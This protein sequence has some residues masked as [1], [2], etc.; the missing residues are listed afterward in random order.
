MRLLVISL[1]NYKTNGISS[2][3]KNLYLSEA[4]ANTKIT[5]LLPDQS[6]PDRI[7]ELEG[8]GHTVILRPDRIKK[9]PQYMALIRKIVKQ[10]GIQIVHVHGNSRTSVIELLAAKQAK[11]SVRI[12]HGHNTGTKS[13][14]LHRMLT[15]LF[16]CVCTD[17][18]ACG[19]AAG[20][21][22]HGKHPFAVVNN[23]I[24]L[25]DFLFNSEARQTI[26]EKY[27]L[28]DRIVIGHV[29]YFTVVKNQA[30]LVD[31]L[32]KLHETDKR[33]CL[34]LIGDGDLQ[35]TVREKAAALGLEQDVIFAGTTN[36]VA[37]YLSAF[38][39]VGMPSLNEGLPVTLIEQQ[40]SGL[41]CV[42]ADSI[43]REVDK[44][45]NLTFLPL[46]A[47][48]QVWA[49]AIL[50]L[51]LPKDRKTFSAEA[52]ERIRVCGYDVATEAEKLMASY[53]QMIGEK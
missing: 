46:E 35:R 44:T 50:Q 27:G 28:Q 52:A 18:M 34:L 31:I 12:A 21:F 15:P 40:A 49:D 9:M 19:Q 3:I 22:M 7:R 30:F 48:A 47:G 2:V 16:N 26:R 25:Q 36:Q 13:L 23:G 4:F 1:A 39:L 20:E 24:R 8:H 53:Q 42:V 38:D 37:A 45:G 10:N 32:Q 43:T 51:V 41:H 14:L 6:D 29:G 11:C 5:F 33:Y 17:R